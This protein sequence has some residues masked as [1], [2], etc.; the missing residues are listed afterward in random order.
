M[1]HLIEYRSNNGTLRK[2]LREELEG[3]GLEAAR[4]VEATLCGNATHKAW[5]NREEREGKVQTAI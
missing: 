2:R 5:R 4:L 3:T 1:K